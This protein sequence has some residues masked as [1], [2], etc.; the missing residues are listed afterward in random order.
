M[1]AVGG[2]DRVDAALDS[3]LGDS[4]SPLAGPPAPTTRQRL[5]YL[6]DVTLHL[7]AR[8]FATRHRGALLGWAWALAPPLLQLVVTYFLFKTASLDPYLSLVLVLPLFFGVGALLYVLVIQRIV[9]APH[10]AH[11]PGQSS[12]H[13]GWSGSPSTIASWTSAS[14]LISSSTTSCASSASSGVR[15]TAS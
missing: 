5:V 7:V 4:S 12:S 11:R 2:S 13:S 8:E 1:N 6:R 3:T 14:T 10:S 9:E 15:S